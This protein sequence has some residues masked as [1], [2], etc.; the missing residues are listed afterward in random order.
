MKIMVCW[1]LHPDK[2]AE[3]LESFGKMDLDEYKNQQADSIKLVGRWHDMAGGRGWAVLDT[4]DAEAV[5]SWLLKWNAAVD[6]DIAIVH[7]DDDAHR[8]AQG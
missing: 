8:L 7:E 5:S 3:V 2:R 1:T 6:F 4:D